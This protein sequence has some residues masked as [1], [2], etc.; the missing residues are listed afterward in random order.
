MANSTARHV[1]QL[2][3]DTSQFENGI[4]SA[5]TSLARFEKAQKNATRFTFGQGSEQVKHLISAEW[6]PAAAKAG[7]MQARFNDAIGVGMPASFRSAKSSFESFEPML[8]RMAVLQRQITETTAAGKFKVANPFAQQTML[9]KQLNQLLLQRKSIIK[10]TNASLD[11]QLEISRKIAQIRLHRNNLTVSPA[12]EMQKNAAWF[13]KG[14]K[15]ASKFGMAVQQGGYQ[16]QDFTVQVMGGQSALVAFAQQGSQFAGIFGP[17]GAVFGAGL[18]IAA[19]IAKMVMLKQKSKETTDS[20]TEGFKTQK[21]AT[22]ALAKAYR[23]L[24]IA[25]LEAEGQTV[26]AAEAKQQF[27]EEDLAKIDKQMSVVAD[28][29]TAA[30][31][32]VSKA[33]E[34]YNRATKATQVGQG[35]IGYIAILRRA[36]RDLDELSESFVKLKAL[37][38]QALIPVVTDTAAVA[39]AKKDAQEASDDII[40]AQAKQGSDAIR[41][42]MELA[43]AKSDQYIFNKAALAKEVAD[44]DAADAAKLISAQRLGKSLQESLRTPQELFDDEKVRFQG[45]LDDKLISSETHKRAMAKINEELID[46]LRPEDMKEKIGELQKVVSQMWNSVSDR[47]SQSMADMVLTGENAF[48]ELA[49]IVARTMLEIAARMAIV[50]PLMNLFGASALGGSLLP[51]WFGAGKTTATGGTIWKGETRMVGEQGPEMITAAYSGGHISPNNR[52]NSAPATIFNITQNYSGGVTASDLGKMVPEMI[53]MTKAAVQ[54][55]LSRNQMRF[56]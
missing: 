54:D 46:S 5:V 36:Q 44:A 7:E 42:Q 27:S 4:Q 8:E 1:A 24:R 47:A 11:S 39:K 21:E 32:K 2:V 22:D 25:R 18:A 35:L 6:I 33:Q 23:E 28:K 20:M 43:Q 48:N 26:G 29:I 13:E 56:A 19:V 12:G 3:S 30:R 52:G 14:S 17:K 40:R 41:H 37:E 9:V 45:M 51:A 10:G 50:N 53:K 49:N 55:A 38:T 34:S 31:L 16:V 15:G